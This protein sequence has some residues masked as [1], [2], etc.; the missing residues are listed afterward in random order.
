MKLIAALLIAIVAA[1][2]TT[3][4][5]IGARDRD[6]GHSSIANDLDRD[7]GQ[8]IEGRNPRP[9]TPNDLVRVMESIGESGQR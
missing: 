2:C 9:A 8:P 7:L 5:N 4:D 6:Y 3:T 1:S